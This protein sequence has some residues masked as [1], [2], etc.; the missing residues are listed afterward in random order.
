MF[1]RSRLYH[2]ADIGIACRVGVDHSFQIA[3]RQPRANRE[4][5]D[6]D[7]FFGMNA[8]KMRSEDVAGVFLD[9]CFVR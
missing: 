3:G 4:S 8:K 2:I 1:A 5:E 6:V 7:H 9:K